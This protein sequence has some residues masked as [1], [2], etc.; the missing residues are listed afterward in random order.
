M[1]RTIK[2]LILKSHTV[3]PHRSITFPSVSTTHINHYFSQ[4]D[5]QHGCN[6][7]VGSVCLRERPDGLC[8]PANS[9]A[10]CL[11]DL[12][13]VVIVP[14]R[15]V[16]T[17]S[18]SNGRKEISWPCVKCSMSVPHACIGVGGIATEHRTVWLGH[19]KWYDFTN[20][21]SG[22][23]S[24]ILKKTDHANCSSLHNISGCMKYVS[25]INWKGLDNLPIHRWWRIYSNQQLVGTKW[26]RSGCMFG[27]RNLRVT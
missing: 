10:G 19:E 22:W 9:G 23:L 2:V 15:C 21:W 4:L 20:E 24:L 11:R 14:C 26:H 18:N 13:S 8:N 1:S 7:F 12:N 6:R 25:N 16:L 5:T 3:L 17:R 27:M